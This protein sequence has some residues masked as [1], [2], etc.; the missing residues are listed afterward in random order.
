M[1]VMHDM[2]EMLPNQ[3][4][5]LAIG[6][7]LG[8]YLLDT[9]AVVFVENML[10]FFQIERHH[11]SATRG[12]LIQPLGFGGFKSRNRAA[13]QQQDNQESYFIHG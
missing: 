1:A 6:D 13:S 9:A 4:D 3:I 2:P 5:L 11:M 8:N 10:R 12:N 7:I